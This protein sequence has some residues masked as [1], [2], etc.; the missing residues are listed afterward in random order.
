MVALLVLIWQARADTTMDLVAPP[1]SPPACWPTMAAPPPPSI[2]DVSFFFYQLS[3]AVLTVIGVTMTVVGLHGMILWSEGGRVQ[4]VPQRVLLI[5]AVALWCVGQL[6]ILMAVKLAQEPVIAAVSNF[7]IIVNAGLGV[8]LQGERV[9]RRDL[10]AMCSMI[11]GACCVVA[12]TPQPPQLS[13][14]TSDLNFLFSCSALPIIG[15]VSTTILTF[16]AVPPAVRSIVRPAALPHAGPGEGLAFGLLAGYA[17]ATSVTTTKL[18]WLMFDYYSWSVVTHVRHRPTLP[19]RPHPALARASARFAHTHCPPPPFA[20]R[21]LSFRASAGPSSS[22][23]SA[24]RSGCS[25][26]CSTGWRGTSRRS[27]WRRTTSR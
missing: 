2:S 15:L 25:S 4:R 19:L 16:A 24:A 13:L 18:C 9:T 10:I 17:G 14:S 7:A 21:R 5:V 12:F 3:G 27:W 23:P 11:V 26:L 1:S 8:K 22:S 20:L 6:L